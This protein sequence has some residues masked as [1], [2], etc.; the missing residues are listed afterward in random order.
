MLS[1]CGLLAS[2]VHNRLLK[3]TF[4][5][6]PSASPPAL[7]AAALA[8]TTETRASQRRGHAFALKW[9]PWPGL[10]RWPDVL[11]AVQVLVDLVPQD[12]EEEEEAEQDPRCRGRKYC[13]TYFFSA[14]AGYDD[15][16][17]ETVPGAADHTAVD[18]GRVD[19]LDSDSAVPVP[20]P[21]RLELG[22]S[23]VH[24]HVQDPAPSHDLAAE[25]AK[26]QQRDPRRARVGAVS[27]RAQGVEEEQL[28]AADAAGEQ[29]RTV[30]RLRAVASLLQRAEHVLPGL[31]RSEAVTPPVGDVNEWT[32]GESIWRFNGTPPKFSNVSPTESIVVPDAA[33][34]AALERGRRGSVVDHG[35]TYGESSRS[36]WYD[37]EGRFQ[38]VLSP[39]VPRG[40]A[41][42]EGG[43]F[44]D[45]KEDLRS[46]AEGWPC[47]KGPL[48]APQEG[49][50]F[51]R[52]EE[53]EVGH[54]ERE[55]DWSTSPF[56]PPSPTWSGSS[57]RSSRSRER[58]SPSRSRW[59]SDSRHKS[60]KSRS[61]QQS[62]SVR[63]RSALGKQGRHRDLQ[64]N[65]RAGGPE[66]S[67]FHG[68]KA[69]QPPG[70][71][72]EEGQEGVGDHQHLWDQP[73]ERKSADRSGTEQFARRCDELLQQCRDEN[74]SSSMQFWPDP[75]DDKRAVRRV[76]HPLR[77]AGR[78]AEDE[79]PHQR[80]RGLRAVVSAARLRS[81]R[82]IRGDMP[83]VQGPSEGRKHRQPRGRGQKTPHIH[84]RESSRK[85][86]SNALGTNKKRK[87]SNAASDKRHAAP[88]DRTTG[89]AARTRKLRREIRKIEKKIAK[90]TEKRN[91]AIRAGQIAKVPEEGVLCSDPKV[92]ALL[93]SVPDW[94]QKLALRT[95]TSNDGGGG[96]N[97]IASSPTP[98]AP[99]TLSHST[100]SQVSPDRKMESY[101]TR[102]D[103]VTLY[104]RPCW[105]TEGLGLA[106]ATPYY[107]YEIPALLSVWTNDSNVCRYCSLDGFTFTAH[108]GLCCY[109]RRIYVLKAKAPSF[110]WNLCKQTRDFQK[111]KRKPEPF[112]QTKKSAARVELGK[113]E[114]T[115]AGG[116]AGQDCSP[117]TNLSDADTKINILAG[118][119]RA[120]VERVQTEEPEIIDLIETSDSDSAAQRLPT[121]LGASGAMATSR[122]SLSQPEVIEGQ[123]PVRGTEERRHWDRS[124]WHRLR[125]RSLTDRR[126]WASRCLEGSNNLHDVRMEPSHVERLQNSEIK[127]NDGRYYVRGLRP[128]Q[129]P[130]YA[131]SAERYARSARRLAAFKLA[132]AEEKAADRYKLSGREVR[133]STLEREITLGGRRV[134]RVGVKCPKKSQTDG[135]GMWPKTSIQEMEV[136]FPVVPTGTL[137]PARLSDAQ[138]WQKGRHK[139]IWERHA[140]Y[141]R[142]DLHP[143]YSAWE[144][145]NLPVRRFG[146]RCSVKAV[147]LRRSWPCAPLGFGFKGKCARTVGQHDTMENCRYCPRAFT[148]AP[149]LDAPSRRFTPIPA[150]VE[151]SKN[152]AA[153]IISSSDGSMARAVLDHAA[154][155]ETLELVE[156]VKL[157]EHRI[158]SYRTEDSPTEEGE[159][160]HSPVPSFP[161]N[162]S[163]TNATNS[164]HN[165]PSHIANPTPVL[166]G[167]TIPFCDLISSDEDAEVAS[168]FQGGL[169]ERNC[170]P[171]KP[172]TAKKDGS[173]GRKS[174]DGEASSLSGFGA[175]RGNTGTGGSGSDVTSSTS[176]GINAAGYLYVSSTAA[177]DRRPPDGGAAAADRRDVLPDRHHQPG[178]DSE[179]SSSGC[180][181]SRAGLSAGQLGG[182][183]ELLEP[184]SEVAPGWLGNVDGAFDLSSDDDVS[185]NERAA[186]TEADN[187]ATIPAIRDRV[188]T[189]VSVDSSLSISEPRSISP[190][191]RR[192]SRSRSRSRTGRSSP[193]AG[194]GRTSPRSPPS[195]PHP[196]AD[197]Q[198]QSYRWINRSRDY[199]RVPDSDWDNDNR[200]QR[201]ANARNMQGSWFY[202]YTC[203]GRGCPQGCFNQDGTAIQPGPEGGG[204][205]SS[206]SGTRRGGLETSG[207]GNRSG[208]F[209]SSGT[210]YRSGDCETS[211]TGRRCDD[212]IDD[213]TCRRAFRD[214][215]RGNAFADENGGSSGSGR[216]GNG[217]SMA[218]GQYNNKSAARFQYNFKADHGRDHGRRPRPERNESGVPRFARADGRSSCAPS[219]RS[220]SSSPSA[221][222]SGQPG[223]RSQGSS[224]HFPCAEAPW[225]YLDCHTQVIGPRESTGPI[226]ERVTVRTSAP[227]P[228]T[229]GALRLGHWLWLD[230]RDLFAA[231]R[232]PDYLLRHSPAF[233]GGRAKPQYFTGTGPA[234]SQLCRE[235]TTRSPRLSPEG[236]RG[237]ELGSVKDEFVPLVTGADADPGIL[238]SA[239]SPVLPCADNK[240]FSL[241]AGA[242][243]RRSNGA[244]P[245]SA[246]SSGAERAGH[247][248]S[249]RILGS[250]GV[251]GEHP[252]LCRSSSSVSLSGS[253]ACPTGDLRRTKSSPGHQPGAPTVPDQS[254]ARGNRTARFSGADSSSEESA[255]PL[256]LP[257]HSPQKPVRADKVPSPLPGQPRPMWRLAYILLL[258]TLLLPG[259]LCTVD[260][261]DHSQVPESTLERVP[262]RNTTFLE[263]AV[264]GMAA[265]RTHLTGVISLKVAFDDFNNVFGNVASMKNK[266]TK[267]FSRFKGG[268]DY[269]HM[270]EGDFQQLEHM[271]LPLRRRLLD[272][273]AFCT[274]SPN[275]TL[276]A[277]LKTVAKRH[278]TETVNYPA[279]LPKNDTER[280]KRQIAEIFSAFAGTAALGLSIYNTAE[281]HRLSG[282]VARL[283]V[284]QEEEAFLITELDK[285]VTSNSDQ[286]EQLTR[287]EKETRANMLRTSTQFY[288]LM[289]L[290][291]LRTIIFQYTSVTERWA[292]GLWTLLVTNSMSEELFNPQDLKD[293]IKE[294]SDKANKHAMKVV[295]DTVAAVLREPVSHLIKN[296]QI[297]FFIHVALVSKSELKVYKYLPIPMRLSNGL[298]M[299]VVE[300]RNILGID[301]SRMKYVS[302]TEQELGD[303]EQRTN[304]YYMCK[305][306]LLDTEPT[307][308]SALY[309]NKPQ[310]I[311]TCKLEIRETVSR[312]IQQVSENAFILYSPLPLVVEKTC[313]GEA[314]QVPVPA[315]KITKIEAEGGCVVKADGHL[316]IPSTRF[317]LNTVYAS[318]SLQL[319]DRHYLIDIT[320][321]E[322]YVEVQTQIEAALRWEKP[323]ARSLSALRASVKKRKEDTSSSLSWSG[324]LLITITVVVC[325]LVMFCVVYTVRRRRR[326]V[327]SIKRR[328]AQR[329]EESEELPLA[330]IPPNTPIPAERKRVTV[331]VDKPTVY[332]PLPGG[333]KNMG[334]DPHDWGDAEGN[335]GASSSSNLVQDY[336]PE[337]YSGMPYGTADGKPRG[338]GKKSKSKGS[339]MEDQ[340][341]PYGNPNLWRNVDKVS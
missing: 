75:V 269:S 49:C 257:R 332:S 37:S 273:C 72:L 255:P 64:T 39:D 173:D 29:Q 174:E 272:M 262:S 200:R 306:A 321:D 40:V 276:D 197:G 320:I 241:G 133:Q 309:A 190:R 158:I 167:I 142:A 35:Y 189:A 87:S 159:V 168:L 323:V 169:V 239:F 302:M 322:L 66:V 144:T 25:P 99:R 209:E 151:I 62:E 24:E 110:L 108:A 96:A 45:S 291:K 156:D 160:P 236:L 303:C 216:A 47:A 214:G 219:R 281:I 179:V 139:P 265:T 120:A 104:L 193:R 224:A 195:S 218:D 162:D 271:L 308:L 178:D 184:P 331:S 227:G 299:T 312:F 30:I 295:T 282:K 125:Y 59:S 229:R 21:G 327:L 73:F 154:H 339:G 145:R 93:D 284:I 222:G 33:T 211:G 106:P 201:R 63:S 17:G 204:D 43:R 206:D 249:A 148:Q 117:A 185:D 287:L 242:D 140:D 97:A 305:R 143:P 42:E 79:A 270:I 205:P 149:G 268:D 38:A 2:L 98:V 228:G 102:R 223:T 250:C 130:P 16:R 82:V 28:V 285:A 51:D 123:L 27:L 264:M 86:S 122:G 107:A 111:R 328:A 4:T 192:R 19:S 251:L 319:L 208:G 114:T 153:P 258:L 81:P 318:R 207:T 134:T 26:V 237:M 141:L 300:D 85:N 329:L 289:Y 186:G 217:G 293:G 126:N 15:L 316:F 176:D 310:H 338:K 163:A 89:N 92:Q 340:S 246:A 215:R 181:P 333:S 115:L 188:E 330:E 58:R 298:F 121:H 199:D 5:L 238:A 183:T 288:Y 105:R 6:Y 202:C 53:Q 182:T 7:S 203:R 20:L 212:S 267:A 307:C 235:P 9:P 233:T 128:G 196:R 198:P 256:D 150:V 46:G 248:S 244:E 31:A 194:R 124:D 74:S 297:Q 61:S 315:H 336:V 119:S 278:L 247:S 301:N 112:V 313:K 240:T 221:S 261:A 286:I 252:S 57:I 164:V 234:A 317:H 296:E 280:S 337:T 14:A 180:R 135:E 245:G 279:P 118:S 175:K 91:K 18:R 77:P 294:A 131:N 166:T 88:G 55:K 275:T 277:D 230:V 243:G 41:I 225:T 263:I 165:L 70:L 213:G 52:R 90:K 334:F 68:R 170:V 290:D 326:Q 137:R 113:A 177:G 259:I 157:E 8:S 304:N 266:M 44:E 127:S 171:F 95:S 341:G 100:A 48:V 146:A 13:G 65:E 78:P 191:T 132:K 94:V 155:A 32:S 84:V 23:L 231:A 12:G 3:D 226:K 11:P 36:G 311:N 101:S 254:P 187:S 1:V 232:V 60:R 50:S 152:S 22:Q 116:V 129:L 335:D 260:H 220:R 283:S 147:F 161:L 56:T 71:A 54:A 172:P 325:N 138:L 83:D 109:R 34:I 314:I 80:Q 274:C 103:A 210:G 67:G 136:T 10:D 69:D 324:I 253:S 292:G 76:P